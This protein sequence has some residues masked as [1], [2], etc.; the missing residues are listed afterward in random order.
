V[1]NGMCARGDAERKPA[2]DGGL[3]DRLCGHGVIPGRRR[4]GT[5]APRMIAPLRIDHF[6]ALPMGWMPWRQWAEF[7]PHTS[8]RA[9]ALICVP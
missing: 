9:C 4:G 6:W 8:R 7:R 3:R 1:Q 2:G 5:G